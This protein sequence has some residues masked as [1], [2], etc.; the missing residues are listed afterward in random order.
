MP[1]YF[2]RR[3]AHKAYQM[4]LHEARMGDLYEWMDAQ[5]ERVARGLQSYTMPGDGLSSEEVRR[6][7][8]IIRRS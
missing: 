4:R 5:L 7:G 3:K 8:D 1:N 6:T 2:G